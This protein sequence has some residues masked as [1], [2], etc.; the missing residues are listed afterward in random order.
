[1]GEFWIRE[2]DFSLVDHIL[3]K[4]SSSRKWVSSEYLSGEGTLEERDGGS[5]GEGIF[6]RVDDTTNTYCIYLVSSEMLN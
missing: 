1:M 4:N 2:V 6:Y 5:K 3:Q